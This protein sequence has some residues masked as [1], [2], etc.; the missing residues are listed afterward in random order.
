MYL[1]LLLLLFLQY[2]NELLCPL[3]FHRVGSKWLLLTPPLGETMWCKINFQSRISNFEFLNSK[4]ARMVNRFNLC[5][6]NLQQPYRLVVSISSKSF[7]S[8]F[9]IPNSKLPWWRISESNRWPLECKSS[10]LASWANP[11]CFFGVEQLRAP[12]NGVAWILLFP[13]PPH[14]L[15]V[16]GPAWTRTTDLYII[17]VAL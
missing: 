10:A 14:S 6:S 4:S 7:N 16:R 15:Y 17:S 8:K 12:P 2:V 3:L 11:P 1:K 9:E 13:D 5:L